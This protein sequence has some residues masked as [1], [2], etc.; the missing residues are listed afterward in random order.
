MQRDYGATLPREPSL[1]VRALVLL[2]RIVVPK[3]PYPPD[4][5]DRLPEMCYFLF[6]LNRE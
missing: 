3:F 1:A 2:A 5:S 6:G 4:W